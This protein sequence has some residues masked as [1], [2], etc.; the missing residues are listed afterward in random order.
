MGANPGNDCRSGWKRSPTKRLWES[1]AQAKWG[2]KS[3]PVLS[4]KRLSSRP[5]YFEFRKECGT[6]LTDVW[7]KRAPRQVKWQLHSLR[8]DRSETTSL[9]E[10]Y[11]EQVKQPFARWER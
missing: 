10:L 5:I 9:V 8:M 6:M 1:L 11:P 3:L 2:W 4:G 7:G